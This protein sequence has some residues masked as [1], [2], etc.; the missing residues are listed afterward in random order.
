MPIGRWLTVSD[1][2]WLSRVLFPFNS[3]L[4][5]RNARHDWLEMPLVFVQRRV[6]R[7]MVCDWLQDQ[8]ESVLQVGYVIKAKNSVHMPTCNEVV[9][10]KI[11]VVMS[12]ICAL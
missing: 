4:L 11:S 2:D 7:L 5:F 10:L 9:K 3:L 8:F 12:V 6:S 1:F